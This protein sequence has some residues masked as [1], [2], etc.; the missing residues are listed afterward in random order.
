ME[1]AGVSRGTF[2]R[3]HESAVAAEA[4]LGQYLTDEI[5]A[6]LELV[7]RESS[8]HPSIRGALGAQSLMLRGACDPDWGKFVTTSAHAFPETGLYQA[9]LKSLI[10]G[11]DAG[12]FD[13]KTTEVA[14]DFCIG[15]A[16]EGIRALSAGR[17]APFSF[18]VELTGLILRGLGL[19]RAQ[20]EISVIKASEIL[21]RAGPKHF[22]W[23]KLTASIE[24][25]STPVGFQT[26]VTE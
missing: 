11:R 2:Y 9:V 1:E 17:P 6:Q 16:I 13:F 8:D 24:Y 4:A 18:I 22:L 20:A 26:S 23:W 10:D 5:R 3:Y 15:S 12:L 25:M 21:K 14:A 19:D 7:A